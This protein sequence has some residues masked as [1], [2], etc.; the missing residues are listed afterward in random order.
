MIVHLHQRDVAF[1]AASRAPSSRLEAYKKRIGWSFKWVSSAA[2]DLNRDY[3]VS[4]TPEE[5]AKGEAYYNYTMQKLWDTGMPGAS[6][7]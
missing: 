3:H 4:Y 6:V 2:N 7:F 5:A 1:V